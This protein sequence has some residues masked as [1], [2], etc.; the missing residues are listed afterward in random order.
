MSSSTRQ[1]WALLLLRVAMGLLFILQAIPQLRGGGPAPTFANAGHWAWILA[2]LIG[3]ALMILGL[4]MPWVCLP[5]LFLVGW[6][7]AH[8]W[9]HGAGFLANPE[10][11]MRLMCLLASAVGGPGKWAVQKG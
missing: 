10:G 9:I 2:E 11:L 1:S 8:G 7:L 3:G 6:P 4:L 5:L